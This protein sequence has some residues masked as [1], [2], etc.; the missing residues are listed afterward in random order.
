MLSTTEPKLGTPIIRVVDA[1]RLIYRRRYQ[2]RGESN[3][4]ESAKDLVMELHGSMLVRYN[5]GRLLV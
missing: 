4:N 3:P 1:V 5:N 2:R